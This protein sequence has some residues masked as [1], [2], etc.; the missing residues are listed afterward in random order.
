M[1]AYAT[2]VKKYGTNR[3]LQPFIDEMKILQE[4]VK[5][6]LV[7]GCTYLVRFLLVGVTGDSLAVQ[8]LF[9][10]KNSSGT[11]FCRQ[12]LISNSEWQDVRTRRTTLLFLY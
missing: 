6:T 1:V 5:L 11:Y 2:D 3:L 12:C 9:G 7:D 10:L 8:P 4:G